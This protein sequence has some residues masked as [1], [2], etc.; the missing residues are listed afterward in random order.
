MTSVLGTAP[1][2]FCAAMDTL[3]S[4]PQKAIKKL[5]LTVLDVLAGRAVRARGAGRGPASA[6]QRRG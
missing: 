4:L 6:Q 3:A 2:G 1:R 5:A